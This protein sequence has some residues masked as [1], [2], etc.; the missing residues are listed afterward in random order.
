MISL[1]GDTCKPDFKQPLPGDA[2]SIRGTSRG[3]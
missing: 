1:S 3:R 2:A